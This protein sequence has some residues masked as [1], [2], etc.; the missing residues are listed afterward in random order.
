MSTVFVIAGPTASGK[1]ALALQVA[2][3]IGGEIINADSMQIYAALPILTA[4]PDKNT[5]EKIPHHLYGILKT[6]TSCSMAK[7]RD[8][9]LEKIRAV[10][11]RGNIPILT[12][13]TG[14]YLRGLIEG[15]SPVP[16]IP[17]EARETATALYEKDAG[18]SLIRE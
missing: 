12:G 7:W 5:T 1:S 16:T 4:Q 8:L 13:G 15:F 2:Q 18:L 17:A 6:D 3:D 11:S 10:Q 9:A 14:L